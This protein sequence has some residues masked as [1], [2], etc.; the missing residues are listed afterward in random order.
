VLQEHK[1][2][3]EWIRDIYDGSHYI[4]IQAMNHTRDANCT[5]IS[6]F[7]NADG[8]SPCK[9]SKQEIWP[10]FFSISELPPTERYK[11]QNLVLA[12]ICTRFKKVC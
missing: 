2:D 8:F 10:I 12:A 7:G 5:W 6:L 11:F 9:G 3:K 1:P 4:R